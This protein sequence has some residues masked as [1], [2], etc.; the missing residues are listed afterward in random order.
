M[1]NSVT[2][3]LKSASINFA[4]EPSGPGLPAFAACAAR[5]FVSRSASLVQNNF[6]SVSLC[7]LSRRSAGRLF[8]MRIASSIGPRRFALPPP[9]PP[10]AVRSFIKVVNA[11]RQPS[12]TSPTRYASGTRVSVMYTS[13]NSASPVICRKGRTSTPLAR[14]SRAKYVIPLCFGASGSVRATSMPQSARWASVF[15]TFCPLMIHSSPS[16]TARVP[17]PAK[18]LPA[19]GSENN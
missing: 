3:L 15:H 1:E 8:Q 7:A 4:I 16:R 5:M 11:A 17:S 2:F 10:I 9:P 14:M 19:P 6:I 18:S 12:P 13:L